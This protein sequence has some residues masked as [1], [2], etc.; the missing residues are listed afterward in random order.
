MTVQQNAA[1]YALLGVQFGGTGTSFNLPDLRGRAIAGRYTG[2]TLPVGVSSQY[3]QGLAAGAETVLLTTATVPPH[4]HQ[5]SAVSTAADS[6]NP[7]NGFFA[8]AANTSGTNFISYPGTG[9]PPAITPLDPDSVSL[10]GGNVG[11]NNMQP[12][13]TLN[14]C[15]A[16][17]GL[18]PPRN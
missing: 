6:V 18:Y 10:A 1:L 12:Y 5:V 7:T 14:Y 13:L 17:S 11:H 16:V 15:I 4:L 3:Q 8:D 2:G 9:T